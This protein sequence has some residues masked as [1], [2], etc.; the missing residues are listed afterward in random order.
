[1]WAHGEGFHVLLCPE[2]GLSERAGLKKKWACAHRRLPLRAVHHVGDLGPK[3]RFLK[4]GG[5]EKR[6]DCHAQQAASKRLCV[7]SLRS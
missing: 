3:T 5:D 4:N 1:V 2:Q 6:A 7:D